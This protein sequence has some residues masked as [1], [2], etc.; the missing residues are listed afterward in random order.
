M[1]WPLV[2]YTLTA[3]VRDRIL[4][5]FIILTLI[6]ASLSNFFG[7]AAVVEQME[8]ALVY[9]AGAL[10][11]AGVICLVLFISFYIRRAF[12][13]REV[14]FLLARPVSRAVY[15]FSHA[16]SFVII[17]AFLSAAIAIIVYLSGNPDFLGWQVWG[18]SIFIEFFIVSL[19]TLFFAM[20]ITSA[21]GAAMAALALYALGRMI[22]TLS[23]IAD[24]PSDH[25]ALT[26]LSYFFDMISVFIPRFDLMGQTSWLVYGPEAFVGQLTTGLKA[27]GLVWFLYLQAFVFS[28]LFIIASIFDFTRRQF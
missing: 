15:I 21:A 25:Q 23:G 2:K 20:V 26:W 3:A 10:R 19:V 18:F 9:K 5:T 11:L 24:M 14:D 1:F 4:L 7:S 17:A 12:E 28:A 8:F 16:T 6:I 22:G 27:I 13:A